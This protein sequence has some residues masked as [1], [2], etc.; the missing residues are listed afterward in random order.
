MYKDE[1][2]S[3]LS[4]LYHNDPFVNELF[5]SAGISLDD[6]SS[7]IN[8]V[9]DQIFFDKLT[10]SLQ[11]YEN[12]LGIKPKTSQTINDRR[13]TVEAKWKGSGKSDL[14]LIQAVCNSWKNG[15]VTV[16]TEGKHLLIK[17]IHNKM[18]VNQLNNTLIKNFEG[19]NTFNGLKIILQF[20]GQNGIPDDLETLLEVVEEIKP[21]HLPLETRFKY[22]LVKDIHNV[23]T[24][25]EL[26]NT[27]IN[28]FAGRN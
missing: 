4:E 17:E 19:E 28:N 9:K 12:L 18:T 23:M 14:A 10:Y 3:R 20:V 7:L 5:N 8:E 1:L 26:N 16:F 21:A 24:I 6:I 15:E 25:N 11:Y 22:L 13:S 27:F 2:I